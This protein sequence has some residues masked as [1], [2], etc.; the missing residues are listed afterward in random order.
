M[1]ATTHWELALGIRLHTYHVYWEL[2]AWKVFD[3]LV[4][5]VYHLRQLFSINRL[6]IYP[7]RH[8]GLKTVVAG[9]ISPNYSGYGCTPIMWIDKFIELFNNTTPLKALSQSE[10][11]MTT[12]M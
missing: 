4:V 8:L 9:S 1:L 11:Y 6:F 2:D 12:D 10:A 3:I 7:H 5:L